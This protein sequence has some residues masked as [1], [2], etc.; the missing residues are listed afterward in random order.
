MDKDAGFSTPLAHTP[1]PTRFRLYT[2]AS[3]TYTSGSWGTGSPTESVKKEWSSDGE[4][5]DPELDWGV[6]DGE[7]GDGDMDM[8]DDDDDDYDEDDD[9]GDGQ[10]DGEGN[11]SVAGASKES[12]NDDVKADAKMEVDGGDVRMTETEQ[13]DEKENRVDSVVKQSGNTKLDATT[14]TEV[15]TPDAPSPS[16]ASPSQPVTPSRNTYTPPM[17]L[18][19]SHRPSLPSLSSLHVPLLSEPPR[20]FMGRGTPPDRRRLVEWSGCG[21]FGANALGMGPPLYLSP[22]PQRHS[23]TVEV[24]AGMI[25]MSDTSMHSPSPHQHHHHQH[26]HQQQGEWTSFLYAMLEGDGVHVGGAGQSSEASW[27]ELGLGSV[28]VPVPAPAPE[29]GM[30]LSHTSTPVNVSMSNELVAEEGSSSTLRFALG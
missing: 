3:Y 25:S 22:V 16:V 30:P 26:Q 27:Y 9:L 1:S 7:W 4:C 13:A 5:E 24:H 6:D 29:L 10:G 11:G 20:A 8:E 19:P 12:P 23:N 14:P 2:P 21:R 15:S 17:P 18:T 28:P